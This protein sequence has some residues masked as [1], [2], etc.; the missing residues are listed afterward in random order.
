MHFDR[1]VHG[2]RIVNAGS[3]GLPYGTTEACWAVV[4]DG[5]VELRRTPYDRD[6]LRRSAYAQLDVF[7][8]EHPEEATIEFFERQARDGG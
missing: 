1:V 4:E 5:D 8:E 7:L 2:I 3:V 6:L